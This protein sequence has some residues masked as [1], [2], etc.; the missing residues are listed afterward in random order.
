MSERGAGS[1]AS[2]L[3]RRGLRPGAFRVK[4]CLYRSRSVSFCVKVLLRAWS[5]EEMVSWP[6]LFLQLLA[7]I[8]LHSHDRLSMISVISLRHLCCH[9]FRLKLWYRSS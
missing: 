8:I 5:E 1:P 6:D 4:V 9:A 3:Q 7:A 2:F